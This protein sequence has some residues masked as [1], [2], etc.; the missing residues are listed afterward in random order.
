MSAE[1]DPITAT[2]AEY[3]AEIARWVAHVRE[4]ERINAG[5]EIEM[6]ARYPSGGLTT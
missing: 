6:E 4:L 5:L 2:E 1:F 3:E